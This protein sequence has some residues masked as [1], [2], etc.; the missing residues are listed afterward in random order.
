MRNSYTSSF[1]GYVYRWFLVQAVALGLAL[2]ATLALVKY[3]VEPNDRLIQSLQLVQ[4]A[5]ASNAAFGDSHLAWGFV[6]SSDFPT[7]AAEGE[8]IADTEL[9]VRFYFRNKHPGR[10]II[11]GDPHSF[12]AYK[13]DR[14]THGYLDNL[15][16][17]FWQRLLDHH[18]PYLGK[19]WERV[20]KGGFG[21]FRPK[22]ELRWGWIVGQEN[23]SSVDSTLRLGQTSARVLR[24]TPAADFE[25]QEF[26]ESYRRT[27]AFLRERGAEVC[28]L[29]T[30]VS[31]EYLEYASQAGS[32]AAAIDFVRRVAEENGAHYVN[33]FSLYARPE[34]DGY[35]RDMDHLNE[36]GA[37]RFTEKALSACFG[38]PEPPSAQQRA[39][40]QRVSDRASNP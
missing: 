37:P 20:F 13:L 28:V 21:A 12:A 24:Q 38:L 39:V 25:H 26:A 27:L 29:T 9:R 14:A 32:T 11:Q 16:N 3:V 36:N 2:A 8:T 40:S 22:N 6:G 30:P 19:Y 1:K 7:F 15:D 5:T 23:W 4:H 31:Y 18:R 35:F 17:Q 33:F 10:V 34:F